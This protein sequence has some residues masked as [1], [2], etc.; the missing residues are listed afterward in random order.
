MYIYLDRCGA[1]WEILPTLEI[2]VYA[3]RYKH[4][5]ISHFHHSVQLG[6]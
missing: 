4:D 2:K 5:E 1:L 6:W 3:E